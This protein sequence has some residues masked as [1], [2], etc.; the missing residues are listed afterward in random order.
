MR[1][2]ASSSATA[3]TTATCSTR[4]P[5]ATP[6]ARRADLAPVV[7]LQERIG[8]LAGEE[9]QEAAQTYLNTKNYVKVTLMPEGK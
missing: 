7:N 8:R 6:T 1:C 9:I 4:L 5:G 3:R 2:G